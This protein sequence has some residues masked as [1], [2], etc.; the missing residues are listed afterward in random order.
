MLADWKETNSGT[1][2]VRTASTG[3]HVVHLAWGR[4]S[5]RQIITHTF[6]LQ[7]T[8]DR[9]ARAGARRPMPLPLP[10][11][12]EAG[13]RLAGSRAGSYECLKG[14]V[15]APGLEPDPMIKNHLLYQLSYAPGTGPEIPSGDGVV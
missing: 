5:R 6:A 3:L 8:L 11:L 1:D 13:R 7:Q 4:M 15:G 9:L 12:L 14:L 10:T 2:G